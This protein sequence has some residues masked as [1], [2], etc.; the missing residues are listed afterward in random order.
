MYVTVATL[1]L[2][3]EAI[4]GRWMSFVEGAQDRRVVLIKY[5]RIPI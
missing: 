1:D 5:S 3:T 4:N 2:S